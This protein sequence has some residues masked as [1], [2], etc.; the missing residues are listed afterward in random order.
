MKSDLSEKVRYL[1]TLTN[2]DRLTGG[3]RNKKNS[4]RAYYRLNHALY[5]R[6]HSRDGFMHFRVSE[7]GSDPESDIRYQA[8][9]AARYIKDS[10]RVLELGCGQGANLRH[11]ASVFPGAELTGVDLSPAMTKDD[12]PNVRVLERDYNSLPEFGDGYFDAVIAIE[13][14]V[15]NTDKDRT[16]REINRLLKPGGT[17]VVYD[18][19]LTRPFND[20]SS[21]EKTAIELISKGGACAVIEPKADWD[22]YFA[23]NGFE[24]VSAKDMREEMLPDLKRLAEKAARILEGKP[25]AAKAAFRLAPKHMT[26]N[27]IIGYLGYD[28]CRDNVMIYREWIAKRL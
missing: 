12:P 10:D 20:F 7:E 9:T 15:H 21:E 14:I 8:N 13:T 23:R 3:D 24:I 18:Y 17:L 1:E 4:I 26:N 25:A 6:H 11:L 28:A 19:V 16:F 22:A 2:V 5:R 27:V